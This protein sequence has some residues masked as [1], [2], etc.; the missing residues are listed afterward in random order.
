MKTWFKC[1]GC[2][3]HFRD[4]GRQSKQKSLQRG[5]CW[6]EEAGVE[7][8]RPQART[9]KLFNKNRTSKYHS[10]LEGKPINNITPVPSVRKPEW[11]CS[12]QEICS[13][14]V[15]LELSPFSCVSSPDFTIFHGG[16]TY[17]LHLQHPSQ[18]RES[19]SWACP[20][21]F[22]CPVSRYHGVLLAKNLTPFSGADLH[23][24]TSSLGPHL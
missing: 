13:L 7:D 9:W 5:R 22:C 11:A 8:D 1:L 24:H 20:G 17:K 10:F 12:L 18:P 6:G 19:Q 14:D 15:F 4:R 23:C 2:E 16:V 21:S 3:W